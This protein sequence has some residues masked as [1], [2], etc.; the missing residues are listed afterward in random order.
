MQS[1]S[2]RGLLT[3][4]LHCLDGQLHDKLD[5]RRPRPRREILA[6]PADQTRQFHG[7]RLFQRTGKGL[8]NQHHVVDRLFG[9]RA[10]GIHTGY[11]LGLSLG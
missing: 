5:V 8:G 4:T 2:N 7:P 3:G 1:L 6:H 11:H 10:A 9:L